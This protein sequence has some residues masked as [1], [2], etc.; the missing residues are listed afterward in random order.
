MLKN[1]LVT[2]FEMDISW[3]INGQFHMWPIC[4]TIFLDQTQL[5]L[6]HQQSNVIFNQYILRAFWLLIS[7][8]YS[9]VVITIKCDGI[10][11]N[12][13]LPIIQTHRFRVQLKF[14]FSQNH[15]LTHPLTSCQFSY[16]F[17]I[18]L[19]IILFTLL[20]YAI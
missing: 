20:V 14:L 6:L 9:R 1:N 13:M 17:T 3:L 7:T 5:G 10:Y 12:S 4:Y 2:W 11:K 15:I 19:C 8:C 18:S 16:N